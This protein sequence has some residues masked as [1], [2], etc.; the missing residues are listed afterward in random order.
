MTSRI[1]DDF[2]IPSLKTSRLGEVPYNWKW[3]VSGLPGIRSIRSPNWKESL[4]FYR[5][6]CFR[7]L[8]LK[9]AAQ[10][11]CLPIHQPPAHF[12]RSN[13]NPRS[14]PVHDYCLSCIWCFLGFQHFLSLYFQI[15]SSGW[16]PFVPFLFGPMHPCPTVGW[17]C[18]STAGHVSLVPRL[19]LPW[20]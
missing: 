11:K 12:C 18:F 1:L 19:N 3:L 5:L 2:L 10:M 20:R 16:T 13:T 7:M 15:L 6:V 17:I 8:Y 9:H 14:T 4:F